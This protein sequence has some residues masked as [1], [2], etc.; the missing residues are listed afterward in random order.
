MWVSSTVNGRETVVG[1]YDGILPSIKKKL[2]IY[3]HNVNESHSIM[4][5]ERNQSQLVTDEG[6]HFDDIL[7]KTKLM[8][9]NRS[10][11]ARVWG[12]RRV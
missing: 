2:L 1:P 11:V 9:G 5:R 10:V 8:I 12:E 6:F 4:P 7:K 3:A